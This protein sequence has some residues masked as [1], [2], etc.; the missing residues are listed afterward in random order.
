MVHRLAIVVWAL[1]ALGSVGAG[2]EF[3][4][5]RP[6]GEAGQAGWRPEAEAMRILPGPRFV[7]EPARALLE[8]RVELADAMG[9]SVKASGVYRFELFD[10]AASEQTVG[11]RDT[12]WEIDVVRLEEHEA[13]YDPVTRAYAFRLA[14]EAEEAPAMARLLRVTFLPTADTRRL[15]SEVDVPGVLR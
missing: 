11:A 2:C 3:K 13:H 4:G 15:E 14:L 9:D 6:F 5:G 7:D 8:V 1:A 10:A 12:V